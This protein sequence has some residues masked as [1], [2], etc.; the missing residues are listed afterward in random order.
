MTTLVGS[1]LA[2]AA[3][4]AAQPP[5]V[6]ESR[7][8]ELR[9]YHANEG[10]LDALHARFRDHTL[11]LFEKNGMTSLGYWVP[12]DNKNN[13][14]VY[15]L[16]YPDAAARKRSWDAF[17]MD[18]E[19]RRAF[20]ASEKDGK[21]VAK[22][23]SFFFTATDFSPAVKPEK[24][25]PERV[26]ELRTYTTTPGNLAA[27]HARFRDHTI[28]LFEKHGMTNV[29]YW[30]L[31]PDQKE[32]DTKLIYLLAHKSPDAAKASFDTFRKDPAWLEVRAASEKK[33]GGSLTEAKGG[34]VSEFLKATEYSPLK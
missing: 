6:Q 23:E 24:G 20:A 10:K 31:L 19:W 30:N 7:L 3:L 2:A 18:A 17:M 21:L 8:F 9:I 1:I 29:V 4:A 15:L 13:K 14:L 27:L 28:K 12:L 25:G 5:P 11:K 22:A 26:F 32:A 16:A 34:V 33:G